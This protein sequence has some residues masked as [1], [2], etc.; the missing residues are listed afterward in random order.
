MKKS[1]SNLGFSEKLGP[2][3]TCKMFERDIEPSNKFRKIKKQTLS[4]LMSKIDK[5]RVKEVI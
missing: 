5:E 4:K 2:I 3:L 1:N